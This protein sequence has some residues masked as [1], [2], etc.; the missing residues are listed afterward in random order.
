MIYTP[1]TMKAMKICFAAHRDQIDKSGVPYVFHPVHVAEQMTDEYTTV[2]ALLH[3]TVE[4]T[5]VTQAYLREQGFP[6]EVLE[7]IALMTHDDALPYLDYV[8]KLKDNPIARAVKLAD[9]AHNSDLTRLAG[10]DEKT[11]EKARKRILKYQ[12]AMEIL[13]S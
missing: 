8:R 11:L 12:K 10:A 4:D 6:E 5:W 13:K 9:L 1:L 2:T 3:D 7:A